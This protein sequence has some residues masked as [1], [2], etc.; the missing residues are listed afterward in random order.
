ML[1][2]GRPDRAIEYLSPLVED[3]G[4]PDV[5]HV[6]AHAYAQ[7]D[8]HDSALILL[9]LCEARFPKDPTTEQ[10]R[11]WLLGLSA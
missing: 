4:S 10:L 7:L 9:G 6:L 2:T 1:E 11:S 5:Y 3:A 8:E